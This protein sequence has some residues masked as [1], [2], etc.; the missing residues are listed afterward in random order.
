MVR[1]KRLQALVPGRRARTEIHPKKDKALTMIEFVIPYKLISINQWAAWHWTEKGKHKSTIQ[2]T[3]WATIKEA[4]FPK[5]KT[6][7]ALEITGYFKHK[8]KKDIDN[9]SG[10][11]TIKAIIDGIV[12]S[13]LI[14]D[15]NTDYVSSLSVKLEQS[16]ENK[17]KI[18]IKE[19]K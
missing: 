12:D 5:P 9:Y 8:K 2:T 18:I 6:P 3:V 14:P 11:S 10:G 1:I 19:Q 4:A 16:D 7:V 15:D 17:I 13:G